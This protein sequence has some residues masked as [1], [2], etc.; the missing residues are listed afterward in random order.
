MRL[1]ALV[2]MALVAL[3]GVG[4]GEESASGEE[5]SAPAKTASGGKPAAAPGASASRGGGTRVKAVGSAYG[6]VIANKK[7]EAFY[8]FGRESKWQQPLLRSLRERLAAGPDQGQA[9]GAR[10]CQAAPAGHDQA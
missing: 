1:L 2:P 7:G 6:R 4:C 5:S 9:G 10:W 8:L 3:V